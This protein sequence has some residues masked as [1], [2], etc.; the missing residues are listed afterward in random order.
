MLK[1]DIFSQIN[2]S[3]RKK[4]SI[5]SSYFFFLRTL[6]Y[7]KWADLLVESTN[8][9]KLILCSFYFLLRNS[10]IKSTVLYPSL[11]SWSHCFA[12]HLLLWVF[13]SPP[14]T[15]CFFFFLLPDFHKEVKLSTKACG[16]T[17]VTICWPKREHAGGDRNLLMKFDR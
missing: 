4:K 1:Y 5:L 12:P 6:L 3:W 10:F 8:T 2:S 13:L 11:L 16:E 9:Y 7:S 17:A 14:N 15:L